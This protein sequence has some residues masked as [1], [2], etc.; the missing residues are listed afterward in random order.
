MTPSPDPGARWL[1][2]DVHVHTPFDAERT[3][4]E[5]VQHAI[6]AFRKERPEKLA[7]IARNF[8]EACRAGADAEGIDLSLSQTTTA[9]DR[10]ARSP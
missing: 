4:G 10:R 1:R 2:C 8:I 6:E 3:F 5:N 9:S 7:E